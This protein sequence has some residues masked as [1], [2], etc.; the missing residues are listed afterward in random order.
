MISSLDNARRRIAVM[1]HGSKSGHAE[2]V[3][4]SLRAS[5]FDHSNELSGS[6]FSSARSPVVV[7]F[8]HAAMA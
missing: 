7:S 3:Q 5:S 6:T 2:P 8:S 4:A 1:K